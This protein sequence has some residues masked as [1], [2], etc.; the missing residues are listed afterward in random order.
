LPGRGSDG[1]RQRFGRLYHLSS[2]FRTEGGEPFDE[3]VA[4]RPSRSIHLT[5]ADHHWDDV[6]PRHVGRLD[7]N[8]E[9]PR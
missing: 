5:A 9:Q 6:D 8:Q 4:L 7:T 2:A 1:D 3:P